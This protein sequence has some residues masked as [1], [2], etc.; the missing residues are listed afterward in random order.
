MLSWKAISI[1][2]SESVSVALVIQHVAHVPYYI[3]NYGSPAAQY[4]STLS[5]TRNDFR[6]TLLSIKLCSEFLW[7]ISHSKKNW[8]RYHYKCTYIHVNFPLLLSDFNE[9][10]IFS[11]DFR[12]VLKYQIS[13][14]SF[15]WGAE[16]FHADGQTDMT[17]VIVDLRSFSKTPK[18]NWKSL[19]MVIML[20]GKLNYFSPYLPV[21]LYPRLSTA[22]ESEFWP[23]F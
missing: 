5:H 1:A 12:K 9:T 19:V 11:T 3:V 10:W 23:L 2:Y 14:K 22:A 18:K 20:L 6:I 16:L 8:T 15:Q 13:W 21:C 7:N 4:F 17:K